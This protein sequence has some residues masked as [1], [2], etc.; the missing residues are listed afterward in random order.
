[1]TMAYNPFNIFRRNQKIIF[2]VLT[3]FIMLMFTLS[4]GLAGADFFDWFPRWLGSKSKRGDVVCTIDGKKIY[5]S[6]LEDSN[7]PTRG[8]RFQR[9]MAT[10]F[11]NQAADYTR[12]G[13]DNYI[14]DNLS[15]T[16]PETQRVLQ[17][18]TQQE[19]FLA[20]MGPDAG[21]MVQQM[22]FAIQRGIIQSPL[23]R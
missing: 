22:Y 11:M 20:M 5:Q 10:P 21:S 12:R 13:L 8:L 1:M 18:V 9:V 4:S 6:E 7:N 19:R 14:D 2:A 23:A 16:S 15:R 17:S 3:V